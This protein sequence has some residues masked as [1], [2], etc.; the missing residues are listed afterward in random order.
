MNMGI[1]TVTEKEICRFSGDFC[2]EHLYLYEIVEPSL[3]IAYCHCCLMGKLIK[4]IK[5]LRVT[6]QG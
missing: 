5:L 2:E 6:G 1:N 4:E 3:R